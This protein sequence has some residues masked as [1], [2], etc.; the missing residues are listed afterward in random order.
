MGEE[1]GEEEERTENLRLKGMV[2]WDENFLSGPSPLEV[3]S[4]IPKGNSV[5]TES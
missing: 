2:L 1:R 5:V 3:F 4:L